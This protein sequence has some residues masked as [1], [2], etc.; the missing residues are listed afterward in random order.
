M[1]HA[2]GDTMQVRPIHRGFRVA[3]NLPYG[4]AFGHCFSGDFNP[5]N[6]LA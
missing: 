1:S 6:A 5:Q 3:A 2:D 4:S